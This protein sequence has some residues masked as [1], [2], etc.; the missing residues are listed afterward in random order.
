MLLSWELPGEGTE[1]Q[2]KSCMPGYYSMRDLNEDPNGCNNWPL[3]YRERHLPNGQIYNCSLAGATADS[4][5]DYDKD[6]VKQK[7]LEHE[8][9]FKKQVLTR[10]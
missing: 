2:L 5:F 1:V 6:A 4:C 3:H 10:F 9:I 7:I 8:A